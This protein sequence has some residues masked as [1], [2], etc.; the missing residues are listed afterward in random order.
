MYL[1]QN[2][3]S[4][5]PRRWREE[6]DVHEV[7][8][9]ENFKFHVFPPNNHGPRHVMMRDL[10]KQREEASNCGQAGADI[11]MSIWRSIVLVVAYRMARIDI[12][13]PSRYTRSY[14]SEVYK[15]EAHTY[16]TFIRAR[17]RRWASERP[18]SA[19][20]SILSIV[21]NRRNSCRGNA[22]HGLTLD[23]R[24]VGVMNSR[25]KAKLSRKF[26][27]RQRSGDAKEANSLRNFD[28]TFDFS[29]DALIAWSLWQIVL[30]LFTSRAN[31]LMKRKIFSPRILMTYLLTSNIWNIIQMR[32]CTR[33]S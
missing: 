22:S 5:L 4:A 30:V 19:G 24:C 8:R 9:A 15:H 32:E 11:L 16:A 25:T 18:F 28:S 20:K 31:M 7:N 29:I 6:R 12:P 21:R 14:P 26:P 17:R 13:L 2:E 23:D 3:S 33:F 1:R 10:I 27:T